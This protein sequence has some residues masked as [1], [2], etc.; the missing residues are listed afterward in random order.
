ML[1]PPWFVAHLHT[2]QHQ[3]MV[4]GSAVAAKSIYRKSG[5][6]AILAISLWGDELLITELSLSPFCSA[7]IRIRPTTNDDDTVRKR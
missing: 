2:Q 1:H 3:N 6:S 5:E 7:R 4:I